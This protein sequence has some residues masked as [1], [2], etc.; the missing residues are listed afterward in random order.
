MH[1]A[2][3]KAVVWETNQQTKNRLQATEVGYWRRCSW[4]TLQNSFMNGIIKQRL[5]IRTIITDTIN[6]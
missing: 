1:I 2:A 3:H 5:D 6:A 4:D